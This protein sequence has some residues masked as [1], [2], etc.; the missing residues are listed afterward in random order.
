MADAVE[1]PRMLRSGVALMSGQRFAAFVRGVI[2]E[3]VALA[4]G[5]TRGNRFAGRGSR[6]MPC[7]AAIIGALNDLPE[8]AARLGCINTIWISG[9]SFQVIHLPA[10]K[11]RA[12]HIPLF[13]LAV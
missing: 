12:A 6:L 3:L 9:G 10:R 4:L 7:F 11:M 5:R 13:A 2:S 8:P 1:L